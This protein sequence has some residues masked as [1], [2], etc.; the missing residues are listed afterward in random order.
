MPAGGG[1]WRTVAFGV[2]AVGAAVLFVR[3]G[4][5]QL[6]RLEE[7]RHANAEIRRLL[8]QPQVRL[9]AGEGA[10]AGSLRRLIW[11]RVEAIGRYEPAREE[12][13]PGRTWEGT[14]GVELLTPLVVED[15][16]LV[17]VDRGWLPSPDAEH[18]DAA[19]FAEPGPV[20]VKGFL[21]PP[22]RGETP[23]GGALPAVLQR[24]PDSSSSKLPF[25]RGE[26]ELTDGPHLSYALQWFAFAAT[27]L[28]G[29]VAYVRS[30]HR[31]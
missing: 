22:S 4:L 29:F 12:V 16:F 24:L 11:R 19:R 28:V 9:A 27:A 15:G 18:V 10:D 26:P 20:S 21:R 6:H 25:R 1:R 17:W 30:R 3:L 7:R 2:V 5:W 31:T 23:P 13:V 14:P 8:A